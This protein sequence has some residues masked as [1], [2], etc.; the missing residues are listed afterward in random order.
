M[1]GHKRKQPGETTAEYFL[2][3]KMPTGVLEPQTQEEIKA[4]CKEGVQWCHICD[5]F[6]CVDNLKKRLGS[7]KETK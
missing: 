6:G 2:R 3:T 1:L 4:A 7:K 5:D